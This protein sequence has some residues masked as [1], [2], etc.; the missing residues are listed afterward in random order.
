MVVCGKTG[1]RIGRGKLAAYVRS[2]ATHYKYLAYTN[3]PSLPVPHAHIGRYDIASVPRSNPLEHYLSLF[4]RE[5]F[6]GTFILG[7][8]SF[9]HGA[10]NKQSG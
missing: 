3:R 6:D 1:T 9:F 5:C 2:E 4:Y 8:R 7:V 10:E